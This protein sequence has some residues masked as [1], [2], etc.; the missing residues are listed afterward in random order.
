MDGGLYDNMKTKFYLMRFENFKQPESTG[1][2]TFWEVMSGGEPLRVTLSE[3][4]GYMDGIQ[5]MNPDDISHLLIDV[6]RDPVR[7]DSA[8]LTYPIILLSEDGELTT[9]LDGQHRVLKAIKE[10]V[11]IRARV[12]DLDTSPEHYRKVFSKK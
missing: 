10:G 12:L 9:I 5:E 8:D 7:V 4:L 6:E 3:I 1:K 2:D 11:P